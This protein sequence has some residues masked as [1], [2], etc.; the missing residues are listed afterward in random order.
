MV[1]LMQLDGQRHVLLLSVGNHETLS[2]LMAS[3]VAND[4]TLI[5]QR[6]NPVFVPCS[7]AWFAERQGAALLCCLG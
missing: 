5:R 1:L 4:K 7:V 6:C 3:H 2:I